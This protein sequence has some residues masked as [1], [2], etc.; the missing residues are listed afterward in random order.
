M[1][2][3]DSP[4]LV[5]PLKVCENYHAIL[6]ACQ[7]PW[8]SMTPPPT[9]SSPRYHTHDWPGV[10][11]RWGTSKTTSARPPPSGRTVAGAGS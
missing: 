11:A 2:E 4:G 5:L 8:R 10:I 9:T 6:V 7:R 3:A 1:H